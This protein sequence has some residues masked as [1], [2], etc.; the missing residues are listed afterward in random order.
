MKRLLAPPRHT[1]GLIGIL[2]AAVAFGA[3]FQKSGPAGG[4]TQRPGSAIGLYL[5]AMA[6]DWALFYYVWV[7]C[8]RYGTP[9]RRIVGERWAGPKDL[10]RDVAIAVPFWIVWQAA[11]VLMHRLLGPDTAK[12]IGQFLPVSPAEVAVWILVCATAGFTEEFVF[13]GYLQQQ[14]EAWT[15]SAG[16]ALAAQ[17]IGFAV[18]HAYQ[19]W[20]NVAV[21]A[22]LGALYGILFLWRGSAVPGML[23]HA[24]TDVYGGLRMQFLSRLIPF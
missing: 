2:L 22:V 5:S 8:R 20:K 18:G 7:S 14:I 10:A 19:G 11:A 16:L 23:A 4:A 21:I 6:F 24:W 13:R 9:F 12:P 17:A 3:W 1:I 15:G